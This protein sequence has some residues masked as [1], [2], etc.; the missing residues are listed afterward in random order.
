[1]T[2]DIQKKRDAIELQAAL[3][4]E[5]TKTVILRTFESKLT[6]YVAQLLNPE[7]SDGEALALR[8][9]AMGVVETLIGLGSDM[10]HLRDVPIR[11]AVSRDVRRS[12][13]VTEPWS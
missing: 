11:K 5:S 2:D 9:K 6:E 1:M 13:T 10:Q 7:L 12:L 8:F 4:D 3:L